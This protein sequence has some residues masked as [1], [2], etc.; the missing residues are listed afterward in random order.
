MRA[1]K[2]TARRAGAAAVALAAAVAAAACSRLPP[3]RPA[4]TGVASWYGA[5]FHGR[6]TSSREVYDMYD[7]T[8]AHPSLPLGTW[9]QV[10]NLDNGR[11]ITV[12]VNDRGPFVRGRIIDL[13]YAAARV[14]GM[15]GP[16]TAPV[17]LEVLGRAPGSRGEPAFAV[18]VG[19]FASRRNAEDLRRELR[20]SYPPVEVTTYKTPGGTYFRVRIKAPS[21]AAAEALA[22][23]LAAEGR[24]V[25]I[26]EGN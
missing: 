11:S 9:V 14:L 7:M 1:A 22:A 10:T 16:G 24:A 3:P 20:R 23:R 4:Q 13:S 5:D 17:R 19:S 25:L 8:A 15:I 26:V 12:R 18:Q 6:P 21:R 2:R